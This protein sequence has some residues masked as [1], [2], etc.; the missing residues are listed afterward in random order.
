MICEL[1]VCFLD[2]FL[3]GSLFSVVVLTLRWKM[4]KSARLFKCSC[5]MPCHDQR[6]IVNLPK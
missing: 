4:S 3:C 1:I 6:A 2:V 5:S